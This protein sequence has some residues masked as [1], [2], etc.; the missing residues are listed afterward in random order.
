[1]IAS[2]E[3]INLTS[4]LK[5]RGQGLSCKKGKRGD[6]HQ[7]SQKRREGEIMHKAEGPSAW[8]RIWSGE[9]IGNVGLAS[10]DSEQKKGT[11]Y[12]NWIGKGK[13][14]DKKG[15]SQS[16]IILAVLPYTKGVKLRCWGTAIVRNCGGR[17]AEKD[18]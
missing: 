2:K 1:V 8:A 14:V 9:S 16:K 6:C 4:D 18:L 10:L 3:K 15:R 17:K 11:I 13:E 5:W 7:L 12:W